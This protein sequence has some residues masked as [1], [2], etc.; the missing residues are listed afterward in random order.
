MAVRVFCLRR[1]GKCDP[2]HG[3]FRSRDAIRRVCGSLDVRTVGVSF[4]QHQGRD[5]EWVMSHLDARLGR[6]Y[7][8]VGAA[9]EQLPPML[10]LDERD[11]TA[12]ALCAGL[13]PGTHGTPLPYPWLRF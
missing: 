11:R 2:H 9:L 6:G 1:L 5:G 10:A 13:A 3:I 8:A 12:R 7:S 4:D